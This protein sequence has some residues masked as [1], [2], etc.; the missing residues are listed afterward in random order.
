VNSKY[1]VIFDFVPTGHLTRDMW[2]QWTFWPFNYFEAL[3]LYNR[4]R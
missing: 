2:K 1:L 3:C 4:A